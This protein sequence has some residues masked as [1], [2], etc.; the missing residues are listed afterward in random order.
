MHHK[1]ISQVQK[2]SRNA[3][4]REEKEQN[5]KRTKLNWSHNTYNI[6]TSYAVISRCQL[7]VWVSPEHCSFECTP[8]PNFHIFFLSAAIKPTYSFTEISKLRKWRHVLL[9]G[10]DS[11]HPALF[12]RAL[13]VQ[14][15]VGELAE[16]SSL[17]SRLRQDQS[18]MLIQKKRLKWYPVSAQGLSIPYSISISISAA[19][20][21]F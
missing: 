21:I 11:V 17:L 2:N 12:W 1:D 19:S 5:K 20:W 16:L 13:S 8:E 14:S 18:C 7:C 15:Q 9:T 4:K 3:N 6:Q 10:F